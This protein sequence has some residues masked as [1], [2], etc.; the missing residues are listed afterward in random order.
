MIS[1]RKRIIVLALLLLFFIPLSL[2][3]LCGYIGIDI[4]HS[5]QR[6]ATISPPNS[7][8]NI[9]IATKISVTFSDAINKSS[10]EEAFSITPTVE[11]TFYWCGNT[12]TFLPST[13]LAYETQYT[14]EINGYSWR[15]KTAGEGFSVTIIDDLGRSITMVEKP[16]R[17][18]SLAPS[19]TEILFALGLGDKVV[20]VTN[21][22]TYPEEAKEKD[23]VGGYVTPDIEKVV[24]LKP[25]LVLAAHGLPIGAIDALKKFNLSV[26]GLFPKN[27]EEILYDIRLVGE[28]TGQNEN[29][30]VLV[31]DMTQRIKAMEERIK[32]LNLEEKPTVLH[33]IWHDPIW[34]AGKETFE[35][36]LIEKSG[37]VNVA[38]VK[39]YKAI[40]LEEVIKINPEVIITP[41]GTGM[42]FAETN[43]TY[44]YIIGEQRLSGVDAVR[45]NRVY[46]ID[47]DI[48]C[49]PG[50]RIVDALEEMAEMI[51]SE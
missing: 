30:S 41:S 8:T 5:S 12:L 6:L 44:E 20:G 25:D 38:P 28:I 34:I 42:G 36:E 3:L 2:S 48:I 24:F 17:I 33:I 46:V 51:H 47:A 7:A 9:A 14:I 16:E 23:K 40:S 37:G 29:A 49:R 21:Y 45:N 11:G 43:F 13:N 15:F 10:I 31:A 4:S 18:I 22:C 32:G 26:A 19:N 39:R 35:N 1:A 27:I 50:P